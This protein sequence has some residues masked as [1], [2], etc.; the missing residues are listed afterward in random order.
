MLRLEW[1]R[2]FGQDYQVSPA[3]DKQRTCASSLVPLQMG[4]M[5]R[6]IAEANEK[7]ETVIS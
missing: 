4:N 7:L 2:A 3:I 6:Q 5:Q 1:L